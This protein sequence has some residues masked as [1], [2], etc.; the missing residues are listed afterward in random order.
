MLYQLRTEMPSR[1]SKRLASSMT[2]CDECLF[3]NTVL[4]E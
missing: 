2:P 1:V 3:E 4:L